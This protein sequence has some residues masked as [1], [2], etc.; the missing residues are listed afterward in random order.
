[1]AQKP[2]SEFLLI[3]SG[4]QHRVPRRTLS[5][6]RAFPPSVQLGLHLVAGDAERPEILR[7]VCIH[8]PFVVA[9]RYDVIGFAGVRSDSLLAHLASPVVSFLHLSLYVGPSGSVLESGP[10]VFV[11]EFLPF[12]TFLGGI[13]IRFQ[14]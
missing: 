1:M 13:R 8:W 10:R 14:E 6:H 7:A 2:P 3:A 9:V 5:P 4:I 11:G 12:D